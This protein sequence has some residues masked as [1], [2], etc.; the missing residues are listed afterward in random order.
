MSAEPTPAEPVSVVVIGAS[1]DLARKKIVP[2][3]FALYSQGFLPDSFRLFGFARSSFSHDQFRA[4]LAQHLTCR[5]VPESD[6]AQK[7]RMFLERCFYCSGAYDSKDAFLDLFQLMQ[8]Q[9]PGSETNRMFYLATPPSVFTDAARALGN[10]GFVQCDAERPWSRLVVEKPFGR[11]RDSSDRLACELARVFS[12]EQT[13]RIDHY[14]GK[15]AVQNLMALRFAN[16][17]FEPVW[18]RNFIER[19][20]IDWRED[21]GIEGRSGYY[22]RY[23]I[24]RDVVQN[25]LLQVL[26]LIAMDRPDGPGARLARQAK[27]DM[28]RRI[29]PPTLDAVRLGQYAAGSF[30]GRAHPGYRDEE[31]VPA[32]SRTP[33]YAAVSLSLDHDRWRGV[34]FLITAGKALNRRA[35]EVRIRFRPVSG[36]LF[37]SKGDLPPNELIL[38]IQPD[39]A[40]HLKVVNKQPGLTMK[41]VETNLDLKYHVAFAD[42]IP[43]AYERLLLDVIQGEKSLFIHADALAVAWDIFTPVLHEIERQGIDPFPYPFGADTPEAGQGLGVRV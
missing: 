23:G 37:D 16:Q 13:Y 20:H 25:H 38:R 9:E 11:D 29:P 30:Q 19:V 8:N 4:A 1:G 22:D 36:A 6:C 14:L 42:Q 5:Y 32:D 39:E 28:L 3:L 2:A 12:E 17:V 41:L 35:T 34:P 18:N 24:L 7:T 31:G 43:D 21:I 40:I 10:T 27:L 33:T 26:A 15:E